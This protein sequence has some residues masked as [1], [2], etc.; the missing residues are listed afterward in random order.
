MH[1]TI[2]SYACATKCSSRTGKTPI[3]ST[4]ESATHDNG[5]IFREQKRHLCF[6]WM[7]ALPGVG[8]TFRETPMVPTDKGATQDTDIFRE[9]ERCLCFQRMRSLPNTEDILRGREG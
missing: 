7:R 6:Q 3:L 9:Q 2:A 8:D 1:E 4:D 5:D